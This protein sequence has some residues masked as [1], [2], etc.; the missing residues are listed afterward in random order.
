M[1]DPTP[2]A[3]RP[4]GLAVARWRRAALWLA[5]GLLFVLLRAIA[6]D[7]DPPGRMWHGTSTYELV[8]EPPAKAHEARNWA[9]F[10]QFRTNE[11]DNYQ[12]WRPQSPLWVYPLAASMR[13]FGVSYPVLRGTAIAFSAI[14]LLALVLLARRWYGDRGAALAACFIVFDHVGIIY[15]R[16]GLLEPVVTSWL[17][18]GIY[19]LDRARDHLAWLIAAQW[20]FV[21]AFFTKQAALPAAPLFAVACGLVWWRAPGVVQPARARAL[22]LAHTLAL[23]GVSLALILR[24]DYWRTVAW[25]YGHTLFGKA[26]QRTVDLHEIVQEGIGTDGRTLVQRLYILLKLF[27]LTVV[28]GLGELVRLAVKAARTR[29]IAWPEGVAIAWCLLFL[30]P[31]PLLRVQYFDMRYLLPLQLPLALLA[32]GLVVAAADRLGRWS[33]RAGR[34]VPLAVGGLFA[35]IHLYTWVHHVRHATYAFRR[36]RHDIESKIGDRDATIIGLWSAPMVFETSYH[37]YYVKEYFNST[38]EALRALHPTHMLLWP[39]RDATHGII[40]R[41]WP[42]ALTLG[43]RLATYKAHFQTIDLIEV[44]PD[45]YAY[46]EEPPPKGPKTTPGRAGRADPRK[47]SGAKP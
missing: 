40:Q 9:L 27:P 10:G 32:V 46:L 24:E 38:R 33:A 16:A 7:A 1:T 39:K 3:A 41:L 15:G 26:Q 36:A 4:L 19:F 31:V 47:A 44:H 17:A 42:Q 8:A 5:V 28:L 25:N 30:A 45:A 37:Q 29:R 14:G 35:A 34:A 11:V 43:T 6:I 12:F 20:A 21:L 22:V 18:L 23:A 2:A 13:V